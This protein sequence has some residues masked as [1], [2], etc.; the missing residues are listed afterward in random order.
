MG[1]SVGA[2]G[3]ENNIGWNFKDLD[4]LSRSAKTLKRNNGE[5]NAI[6]IGPSMAPHFFE[7]MNFFGVVF[8]IHRCSVGFGPNFRGTDG[9]S[10]ASNQCI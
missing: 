5:A 8:F 10:T 9:K 4:E 7:S 2:V 1:W 3:I 6:L